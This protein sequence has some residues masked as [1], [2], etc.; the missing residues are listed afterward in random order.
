MPYLGHKIDERVPIQKKEDER[1][2]PWV[3][4]TLPLQLIG[5]RVPLC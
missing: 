3:T 5:V 4:E 1:V 2:I